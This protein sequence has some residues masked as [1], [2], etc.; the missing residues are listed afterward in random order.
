MKPWC[1]ATYFPSRELRDS[2]GC[3]FQTGF[4]SFANTWHRSQVM[5]ARVQKEAMQKDCLRSRDL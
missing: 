4:P 2:Q 3:C 1:K 5:D